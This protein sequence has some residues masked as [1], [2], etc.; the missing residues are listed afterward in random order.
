MRN[1]I[2]LFLLIGAFQTSLAQFSSD[3]LEISLGYNIH[4]AY[5][6]R[7]NTLIDD[8]NGRRYPVEIREN[9]GNVNWQHG[10]VFGVN[11]HVSEDFRLQGSLKT[12]REFMQAQYT[13]REE[14][15]QFF[16]RQNTLNIGVSMLLSEEKFFS[17][18]AGTGL[19]LGVLSV[20]TDW[21]PASGFQGTK[22]M[23]DIDHSGVIGLNLNY[24]AHLRLHD[25]FR[26]FVR[27]VVQ[28]ALNSNVRKLS[29]FFAP[30]VDGS[31]VSYGEGLAPKYDASNLN[32]LGIEG[33]ILILLPKL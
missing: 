13:G 11:Y 10:T 14:Y 18:Y 3:K 29:D 20:Y 8:F 26:L 4:N 22:N 12:Q 25:N 32:G 23:I 6:K 2:T 16:F 24:E 9:L 7:F 5:A 19:M 17:H 31:S 15:R 1:L 28:L 30:I 21:T 33:G 27:P